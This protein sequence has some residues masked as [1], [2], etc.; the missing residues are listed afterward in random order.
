M[1]I[2]YMFCFICSEQCIKIISWRKKGGL[3]GS[4]LKKIFLITLPYFSRSGWGNLT[5]H[6]RAS[7]GFALTITTL[8]DFDSQGIFIF[9]VATV[10]N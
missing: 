7:H 8:V 2:E 10:F 9:L 6:I 5:P 1:S 3:F 4:I